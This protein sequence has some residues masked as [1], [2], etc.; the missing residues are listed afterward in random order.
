MQSLAHIGFKVKLPPFGKYLY[1][2]IKNNQYPN[3]DVYI[4][5]GIDAWQDASAFQTSR[6]GTMCLPPC[7]RPQMYDWPLLNCDVLLFDSSVTDESYIETI[8][9]CLLSNGANIVRYV[10]FDNQ[11]SIYKKDF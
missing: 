7:D 1:D 11:L 8:A 3:N 6:P 5:M 10:S 2:C 9:L 4:F